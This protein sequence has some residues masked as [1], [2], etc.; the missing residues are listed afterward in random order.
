[1]LGVRMVEHD[2]HWGGGLL[3]RQSCSV[4]TDLVSAESG[5][6]GL[7]MRAMQVMTV[8]WNTC[9]WRAVCERHGGRG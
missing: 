3:A 1:M 4:G 8:R 9:M 7:S 2:V 5:L 6:F